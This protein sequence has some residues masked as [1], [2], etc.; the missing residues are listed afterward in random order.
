MSKEKNHHGQTDPV[1]KKEDVQKSNDEHIDQDFTGFPHAPA[2]E[3]IIN[4]KTEEDK[5]I[6]GV[7]GENNT[8][9]DTDESES[10]GSGG[11]FSATEDISDEEETR[12]D[13]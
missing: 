6:S 7:D 3:N 4:P 12:R 11:A 1:K 2:K 10:D 8:Q 13:K 9:S 5:A